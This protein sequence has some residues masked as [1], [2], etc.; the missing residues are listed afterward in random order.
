MKNYKHIIQFLFC[1]L[2]LVSCQE[3]DYEFGDIVAPSNI[4]IEVKYIDEGTESAAPGLG[5]GLV[6]F[7]ATADG[8]T[9]YHFVIQGQT[10]LQTSGSV[11]HNFTN[12]GNNTYAVTVVAYGTGGA[13]SSETIEIDVLALYEPPADLIEMLHG[14]TEKTWRIKAESKP[15]FGLGPVDGGTVAEWF[16][17]EPNDKVGVGMYDDRYIFRADGTFTHITNADV[18]GRVGLIDELGASGGSVDGADVLNLPYN[19]YT[20]QYTLTAPSD[21]ETISLSGLG[22]IGYYAGGDHKYRIFS[23]NATEMVLSTTDGNNE[24]E[25]WFVLTSED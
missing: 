4:N 11:S 2:I 25:W 19:D 5:S 7:S 10:K 24:F 21:V 14:G 13:S 15:H 20:E 6:E 12:L 18:F 22:F 23:R 16:S 1:T 17:A 8:A 3:E 9:A